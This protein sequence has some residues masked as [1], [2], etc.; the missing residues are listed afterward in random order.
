MVYFFYGEDDFR[1]T[2]RLSALRAGL[3]AT[4]AN[5]DVVDRSAEGV[6]ATELCSLVLTQSLLSN[7]KLIVI[8][9][10]IENGTEEFRDGLVKLLAQ[11]L[12]EGVVLVLIERQPDQRTKLFKLLNKFIA[13]SYHPLKAPE[14]KQWL[15]QQAKARGA[16]ISPE[17]VDELV[18]SFGHDLWRMNN[19]LNKLELF[20]SGGEID[21]S[22]V[23]LLTPRPLTD[24]IFLA[25]EA[26]AKKNFALSNQLIN[27]QLILGMSEQQLLA[28]IAYQFRNIVMIRGW[29]DRGVKLTDL[30][31]KAQLHPY[32]VQKTAELARRFSVPELAKVFYLLQRVDAAIKTGKTPPRVGLD[33]LTAQI[34]SA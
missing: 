21:R 5:L 16:N 8:N 15:R 20:V 23:D 13:E 4:D 30:P 32:V 33:I 9:Q 25:V 17:A 6:T 24:N 3:L 1:I 18:S 26:L 29:I 14:A 7:S 28:M 11:P 12:P 2:Q 22:V 27:R 10:P 31:A 34:V 19:E